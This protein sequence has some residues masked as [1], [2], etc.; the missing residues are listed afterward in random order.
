MDE[1]RMS[2]D[3]L[4]SA[5]TQVKETT[6]KVSY[7]LK[8]VKYCY[9]NGKKYERDFV[10]HSVRTEFPKFDNTLLSKVL[11]PEK[12]GVALIPDAIQTITGKRDQHRYSKRIQARLSDAAYN[13]ITKHIEEK[14][15]PSV[16]AWLVRLV[17]KYMEEEGL[18]FER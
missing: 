8:K 12:Y 5:D 1:K 17:M 11:H 10:V 13:L 9:I 3:A 15:Y 16:N 14:G 6:K 7:Q 18:I 4:P 2:A